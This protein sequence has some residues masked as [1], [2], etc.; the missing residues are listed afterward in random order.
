[1]YTIYLGYELIAEL[2]LKH[3]KY[4]IK[5]DN[6]VLFDDSGR[7]E[8]SNTKPKAS[9]L[10]SSADSKFSA[11]VTPLIL[12]AQYNRTEIVQMLLAR[13][14]RIVKPHDLKCPCE[15]CVKAFKYDSLRYAQSRLYAYKGLASESY[16]SLVSLDPILTAFELGKELKILAQKENMYKVSLFY[17]I[18]FFNKYYIRIDE[19]LA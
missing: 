14:D 1:M 9:A 8:T 3:P 18:C 6:Q 12:A 4:E 7:P 16:I 13:G 19:F 17:W 5:H 2:I 11:D 10:G 15:Q